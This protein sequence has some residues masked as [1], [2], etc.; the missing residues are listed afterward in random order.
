MTWSIVARDRE[1]GA[2]GVAVT[3]KFFAVG[4]LCPYGR[5][6]VGALSTQALVNPL[7]GPDGLS[8]LAGGMSAAEALAELTG[9]DEGRESRQLHLVDAGG[10]NAAFTGAECVAWAGHRVA[11][12]VS[13]AGN[14]LTGPGVVEDT[15]ACYRRNAALPFAA[16]LIAA[17]D[18]GQAAGGDRRGRQSAAL[19]I[20]GGEDY[21]ELSL[22]VDDH[23]EPLAELRR[24]YQVAQER[25]IPY[26]L[27]LPTRALPSGIH[28]RDKVEALI[29]E[30]LA[31]AGRPAAEPGDDADLSRA[32]IAEVEALHAFFVAWLGGTVERGE[33][34]FAPARAFADDLTFIGPDGGMAGREGLVARLEA[35]H[36]VFADAEPPFSIRIA[37]AQ[38]R[39]LGNGLCL[40]VYEE[41]QEIGGKTN[42]RVSGAVMRRGAHAPNGMEWLHVQETWLP[43]HEG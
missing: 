28:G 1:S 21:P 15:L 5:G 4:G 39:P 24:L 11:E 35:A 26:S 43:G 42:G 34:E 27:S 33:A 22:R 14:M 19:L 30:T 31:Q 40:V 9:R 12:Q 16:R 18:A 17:L 6:G 7:Y 13:V 23:A 41:W 38:A 36:G 2:F 8:L 37:N 25:F 29:E 10:G 3:T 20:Y 32:A